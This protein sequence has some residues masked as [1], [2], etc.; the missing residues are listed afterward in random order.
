M[1]SVKIIF[2]FCT[3]IKTL[4]IFHTI[5]CNIL[6]IK[7]KRNHV[8][9]TNER[10]SCIHGMGWDG[11]GRDGMGRRVKRLKAGR[12]GEGMRQITHDMH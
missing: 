1:N 5:T 11:M 3:N 2:S 9:E 7:Q 6:K 4:K 12:G 8:K 10:K